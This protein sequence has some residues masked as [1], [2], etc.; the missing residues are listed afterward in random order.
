MARLSIGILAHNEGKSIAVTLRSLFGQTAVR[1]GHDCEIVVVPNGCK[2]DTAEV[3]RRTLEQLAA[4]LPVTWR[5]CEL[6]QP[7]KSNAWNRFVHELSR[8]D[9]EYL[10][11]MDADIRFLA[12]DTIARMVQ[13]LEGDGD[14]WV[15]TDVPMKDVQ[16][17]PPRT[18][19]AWLSARVTGRPPE[20]AICGQLYCGR[21]GVLREVWMPRG[22][23]VEDGFL[24]AMMD[25]DHFTGVEGGATRRIRVAP[26]AAHVYE[27]YVGA[28]ALLRHEVRLVI[29]TTINSFIF[30]KLW[31]TCGAGRPAGPLIAQL[32][33]D[34]P[35][36]LDEL[37]LDKVRSGGWWVVPP[38][39]L[40]RRL[41]RLRQ[42]PPRKAVARL[43][44][45]AAATAV[46]L[47]V[48]VLANRQM[49]QGSAV[50]FW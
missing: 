6:E 18:P 25:T 22:L 50:G 20:D 41:E 47:V 31:A 42:L 26:G 5:V 27:A 43:P 36:W 23:P 34:A 45:L 8:R 33:Q 11:L 37:V 12:D 2:D 40:W 39:L 13:T 48:M 32:N 7:G 15:A 49:R 16:V 38:Q 29:G 24:R 1:G 46:D 4:G 44:V 21:A 3:S 17:E 35:G 14:A 19:L 10:V 9:A 28:R 30:Q